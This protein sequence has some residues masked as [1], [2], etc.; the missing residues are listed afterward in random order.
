LN[1][2]FHMYAKR[3]LPICRNALFSYDFDKLMFFLLFIFIYTHRYF[4][5]LYIISQRYF[6][7]NILIHIHINI[8]RFLMLL[9][10]RFVYVGI[11]IKTR[12]LCF[13]SYRTRHT[14]VQ[15]YI[16]YLVYHHYWRVK[17]KSVRQYTRL[18]F[19]IFMM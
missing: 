13:S 8:N 7:Y 14:E 4:I 9:A 11:I 10:F 15:P 3:R 2:L 19:R 1:L 17:F 18:F 16:I 6:H 12:I 5:Y